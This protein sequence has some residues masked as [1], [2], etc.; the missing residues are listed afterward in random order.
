MLLDNADLPR[1]NDLDGRGARSEEALAEFTRFFL[2][3]CIDQVDF[4]ESLVEPDRLRARILLSAEEE[5]R[6]GQLPPTL[7]AVLEA[8]LYRGELP[9][10]EVAAVVGTTER[11]GCRIVSAF[12]DCGVLNI[13]NRV[14][15]AACRISGR[16]GGTMDPRTVSGKNWTLSRVDASCANPTHK[17]TT[18]TPARVGVSLNTGQEIAS[19][20]F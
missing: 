2:T 16:A 1:R 4:M 10:G 6:L 3:A 19:L 8:V 15:A 7:G 13:G 5:I 17:G 12:A 14:L 9:R 18:T 20:R 11:Q